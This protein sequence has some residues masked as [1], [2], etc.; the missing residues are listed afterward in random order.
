MTTQGLLGFRYREKDR[1]VYNHAD[2]EPDLLGLRILHELRNVDDWNMARERI[3]NIVSIPETRKLDEHSCLAET[4]VRRHFPDLEYRTTPTDMYQLYQPLQGSLKPYLDGKLMFMPD[5][6]DFIHDSLH[7]EW[8]YIANLDTELLEVW[9][10]NQLEPDSEDN[11]MSEEENRYGREPDHMGYYPC[12]MVKEYDLKE[13][14]NPGLFL[15]YYSFSGDLNR[16]I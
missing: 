7:C 6:S 4:E 2:S 16:S 13:L 10:G 14:P 8:A 3:K 5:A 12:A 15:T 9:K 11:R 1:L